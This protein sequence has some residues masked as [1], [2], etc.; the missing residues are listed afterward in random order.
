M[1]TCTCKNLR[2]FPLVIQLAKR[3]ADYLLL[4]A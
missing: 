2:F 3:D 4:S 1:F